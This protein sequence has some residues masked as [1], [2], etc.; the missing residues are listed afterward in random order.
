MRLWL[1]CIGLVAYGGAATAQQTDCY[2][3]GETLRCNTTQPPP[4]IPPIQGV[5]GGAMIDAYRQG[6]ADRR[7]AERERNDRPQEQ[8]D[9]SLATEWARIVVAEHLKA[10]HCDEAI[11]AALDAGEIELATQAKAFC[12]TPGTPPE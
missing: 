8:A 5:D 10:G 4:P 3:I 12:A 1:F 2:R 9:S 7:A 6:Q 11:N